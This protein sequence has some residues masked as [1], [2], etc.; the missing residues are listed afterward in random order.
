[1]TK[2]IVLFDMDGTLTEPRS[3][4]ESKSL[5]DTLYQLTNLGVHIGIVT[6]SDLKYLKQQM[7]VFLGR[8]PSRYKTHLLPC[9][10]TKYL[11]PPKFAN[12]DHDLVS[13]M[14]MLDELGS[15]NYRKLVKEIIDQQFEFSDKDIPLS[16]HF[17]DYRG[18]M[19]NWS[20]IGREATS[21]QRLE[22]IKM[23]NDLNLRT[24]VLDGFRSQLAWLE[25]DK[26]VVIK[27]GGDTSFD[28]YPTGWDKTY[29]LKHFPGW[30][31]WFIGDRCCDNGNDFEIFN[32]CEG[33]SYITCGP[34][35]TEKI[36]QKIIQKIRGKQ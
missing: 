8:S 31:L 6:G 21:Q 30:D 23:D 17:I 14:S 13:D 32:A 3:S 35:N 19:I 16:G 36:I 15:E 5:E 2:T 24:N 4:F 26:D 25:I 29:A 20:P 1:M 11:K 7:G 22:F 34:E 27:L 12:Q 18:S 28:V 10:G 33:Q 9:N